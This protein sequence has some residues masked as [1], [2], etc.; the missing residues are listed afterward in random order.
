[1]DSRAHVIFEGRVQGVFFRANTR[2]C[3]RKE[4]VLGWVRNLPDGSVE[5]T[6]EGDRQSIEKVIEWCKTSQPYATVRDAKVEW[7]DVQGEFST[8]E[9]RY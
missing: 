9:V 5:A 7:Q 4:G 1:M 3:A 6:F 2:D 8:F